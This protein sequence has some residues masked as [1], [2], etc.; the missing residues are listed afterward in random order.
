M[1]RYLFNRLQVFFQNHFGNS[2]RRNG[3]LTDDP[4]WIIGQFSG[5]K[6]SNEHFGCRS[7]N[8]DTQPFTSPE[9]SR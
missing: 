2:I 4:Y 8:L 1:N 6:Y 9:F 7:S 3:K 5:S